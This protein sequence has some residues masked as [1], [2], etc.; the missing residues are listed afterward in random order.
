MP[1]A[2]FGATEAALSDFAGVDDDLE[3]LAG[4]LFLAGAAPAFTPE[5]LLP[6]PITNTP[7][8]AMIPA[9]TAAPRAAS[10][11][12]G[13]AAPAAAWAPRGRFAN[14]PPAC[15]PAACAA[16]PPPA[17]P[18]PAPPPPALPAPARCALVQFAPTTLPAA[19][20]TSAFLVAITA[21]GI[22]SR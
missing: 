19:A 1:S 12:R 18:P 21:T 16:P 8:A 7:T 20:S 6:S 13:P 9:V 4:V 11:P 22:H 2:A 5:S 17:P 3:L 10:A 15:A 14:R